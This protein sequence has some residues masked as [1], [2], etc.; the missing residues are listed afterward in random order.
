MQHFK[1]SYT[2]E[3]KLNTDIA[4][5]TS[6]N[7]ETNT[8]FDTKYFILLKKNFVIFIANVKQIRK[9]FGSNKPTTFTAYLRM[10]YT[11]NIF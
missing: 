2:F 1:H 11:Y 7:K 9:N 4:N 6:M 5:F 8:G 10:T 3:C